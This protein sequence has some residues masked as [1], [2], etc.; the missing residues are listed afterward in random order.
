VDLAIDI[1]SKLLSERL[2]D[3]K[4]RALA[5]EFVE[6]LPKADGRVRSPA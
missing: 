4:Q 6:Q 3:A 5:Q 1:A 2:D